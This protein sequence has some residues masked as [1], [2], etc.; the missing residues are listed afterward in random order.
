[1][2]EAEPVLYWRVK[3]DGVWKFQKANYVFMNDEYRRRYGL[4]G[5]YIIEPPKVTESE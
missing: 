3:R 1:M 5:C 4:D 2:H